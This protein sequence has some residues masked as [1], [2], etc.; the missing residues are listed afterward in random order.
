MNPILLERITADDN[1]EKTAVV[2]TADYSVCRRSLGGFNVRVIKEFPFIGALGVYLNMRSVREISALNYVACAVNQTTASVQMDTA[3]R[4]LNIDGF[5]ARGVYGRGVTVAV[6]DTG[7]YPHLDFMMPECRL[8]AFADFV[9]GESMPYD[10][11][12]HGTFV[13]GA[14]C[15]NGLKSNGKYAGAAPCANLIALRAMNKDGEGGA[16]GIL[17][18]MQWIYYNAEKYN[19]RVVCM[20]FGSNLS[21][22]RDPLVDGAE[23]LWKRGITVVAAA[24]NNGPASATIKSPGASSLVITVGGMDDGRGADGGG[25]A[26]ADRKRFKVADFSSRGPV[27]N[28]VKPDIIA[29]AVNIIST[30]NSDKDYYSRMSGTSVAAPMIAGTACLMLEEQPTLTPDQIKLLFIKNART[31]NFDRNSEGAGVCVF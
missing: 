9:D 29:P 10:D 18:A 13:A 24:G 22:G 3:R 17:E 8:L 16:F 25:A 26:A 28:L 23:A 27:G 6:I 15:G 12:G 4:V 30:S 21:G 1:G 11:N 7:I 14:A 19:I 31:I 2:Y 5:H 20:S